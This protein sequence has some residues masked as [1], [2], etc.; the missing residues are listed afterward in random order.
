VR[1]I[2]REHGGVWRQEETITG[3]KVSPAAARRRMHRVAPK[4]LASRARCCSQH[5]S[6]CKHWALC[7]HHSRWRHPH[8]PPAAHKVCGPAWS[9]EV[10]GPHQ[11]VVHEWPPSSGSSSRRQGGAGTEVTPQARVRP[12]PGEAHNER[13]TWEA[14]GVT[15]F[16]VVI[17]DSYDLSAEHAGQHH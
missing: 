11:G 16:V 7:T 9:W 8:T 17:D 13:P 14:V 15:C 1:R 6:C 5:G 3:V 12:G 10:V 2:Q 4:G